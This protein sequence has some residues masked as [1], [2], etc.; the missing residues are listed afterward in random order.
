M[1]RFVFS[2][3]FLL[4]VRR[5]GSAPDVEYADDQRFEIDAKYYPVIADASAESILAGELDDI[6]RK[7]IGAHDL[8][9]R[10]DALL[11]SGGNA[12]EVFSRAIADGDGPAHGGVG[13]NR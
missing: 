1:K 4:S 9:R 11:V 6:A 2:S 5:R 10:E 12:L 3:N 13:S 8:E 7:R